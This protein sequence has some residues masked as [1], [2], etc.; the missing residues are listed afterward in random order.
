MQSDVTAILEAADEPATEFENNVVADSTT[1]LATEENMPHV[2]N[3]L[4]VQEI[5]DRL[6][7][8]RTTVYKYIYEGFL[9]ACTDVKPF[10]IR[11]KDYL[12]FR[13]NVWP[14]LGRGSPGRP[15]RGTGKVSVS[16]EDLQLVFQLKSL[17]GKGR[18]G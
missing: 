6:G 16:V 8:T 18:H 17:M 15:L 1:E 13:R 14:K 4:T 9:P 7:V 2:K 3:T 12:A 10:I 5:G 11:R